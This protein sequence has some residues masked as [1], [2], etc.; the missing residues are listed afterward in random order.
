MNQDEIIKKTLAHLEY[1]IGELQK[2]GIFQQKGL[3]ELYAIKELL[4]QKPIAAEDKAAM[5]SYPEGDAAP[6]IRPDEIQQ[7]SKA[8]YDAEVAAGRRP[9]HY[10]GESNPGGG[11]PRPCPKAA[12]RAA[13]AAAVPEVA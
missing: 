11:K 9:E 6:P 1:R 7:R 10:Q 3:T 4:T 2:G 5:I 8:I 13:A 12:A